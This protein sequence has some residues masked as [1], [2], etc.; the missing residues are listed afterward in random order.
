M[1]LGTLTEDAEA[2]GD[3]G[4]RAPRPAG[5]ALVG[6]GVG[7]GHAAEDQGTGRSLPKPPPVAV[8]R[9]VVTFVPPRGGRAAHGGLG[10]LGDFLRWLHRQRDP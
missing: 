8:P 1:A 5:P 10:A 3:R 2:D 4:G 9:V 7:A 6:A